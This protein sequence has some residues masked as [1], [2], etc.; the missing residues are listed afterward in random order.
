M[1]KRLGA[2]IALAVAFFVAAPAFAQTFP[3]GSGPITPVG[4]RAVAF[5]GAVGSA[6]NVIAV[7]NSPS[8]PMF[9]WFAGV[10][11]SGSN[12]TS[13]FNFV[14]GV[15]TKS[16]CDTGTTK[17]V[18]NAVA[19]PATV[20]LWSFLYAGAVLN[21]AVG[22]L[23]PAALPFVVPAGNDFCLITAGTTIAVYGVVLYSFQ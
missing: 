9:V 11:A 17:L 13:T 22:G 6:T 16:P 18:P 8:Q 3:V 14:Y 20:G 19:T 1:I 15:T 23:A 4:P 21:S 12:S 7:A 2:A 10:Q 5:T